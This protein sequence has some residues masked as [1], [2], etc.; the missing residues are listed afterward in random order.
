MSL[1]ISQFAQPGDAKTPSGTIWGDCP[2]FDMVDL[3]QGYFGHDDFMGIT[4]FTSTSASSAL[5]NGSFGLVGDVTAVFSAVAG[6]GGILKVITAAT[7]NNGFVI[8]SE[9]LGKIVKNSGQK[10]WFE[11][12]VSPFTLGDQA[13]F[14]G[15]TTEANAT[16]DIIAD[17]PSTSARAALTA[18]TVLGFVSAQSTTVNKMDIVYAKA[19]GT[20][21]VVATDVLSSTAITD[22]GGTIQALAAATL[23]KYGIYFDGRDNI[24][25]YVNGYKV[26]AMDVDSTVD[27]ATNMV[28]AINHKSGGA[29]ALGIY[30]DFGRYGF[31]VRR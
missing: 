26:A 15:L 8:R 23:I 31:Q 13:L 30:A 20:P 10:L 21:V 29:T 9:G 14:I 7:D 16:Q 19:A 28:A 27:Q 3:G 24:T 11:A 12:A 2:G 6:Q 5:G 18:A 17:N 1:G 22:Q 4:P 25:F